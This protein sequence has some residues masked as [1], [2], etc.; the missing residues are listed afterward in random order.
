VDGHLVC[1]NQQHLERAHVELAALLQSV[2]PEWSPAAV[3]SVLMTMGPQPTPAGGG[4]PLL[5]TTSFDYG[6]A[7]GTY[8]PCARWTQF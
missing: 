4:S 5:P 8:T 2:Q 1:G 3:R 7:R 6:A